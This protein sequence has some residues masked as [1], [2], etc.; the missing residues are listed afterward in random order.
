MNSSCHVTRNHMVL[1]ADVTL[2]KTFVSGICEEALLNLSRTFWQIENLQLVKEYKYIIYEDWYTQ[3]NAH[4]FA[5][6]F[7]EL[8]IVLCSFCSMVSD[9]RRF[10]FLFVFCAFH[11]SQQTKTSTIKILI[12]ILCSHTVA[13]P[14][15]NYPYVVYPVV[16]SLFVFL[17]FLVALL[18]PS[19]GVTFLGF[20][21]L[22]ASV[23]RLFASCARRTL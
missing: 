5:S 12:L 23:P 21:G 13:Y 22:D 16:I 6:V 2:L 18:M 15:D 7:V 3:G 20:M 17:P 14:A 10:Y 8:T 11:R 4:Y 9:P 19:S 1:F